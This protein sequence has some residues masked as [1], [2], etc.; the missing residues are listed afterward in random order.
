MT[1]EEINKNQPYL[2]NV[3]LG[4]NIQNDYFNTIGTSEAL[5]D[6]LST[7][8]AN[9]PNYSCGR[10]D[11]LLALLDAAASDISIQ[12]ST[13][14][15]TYKV[16]QTSYEIVSEALSDKSQFPFFHPM[17]PKEGIQYP[18]IVQLLLHFR[19]TLIGLFASDTE[20]GENFMR[21]F[22]RMLVR[23]GI[24]VVISQRFSTTRFTAPLRNAI[25]KWRQVNVF[26]HS[27]EHVPLL[28]RIIPFHL[29]FRQ[30]SG[31]IEGKV[32]ILTIFEKHY[33]RRNIYFK[34]IHSVWSFR[35]QEK[36]VTKDNAVYKFHFI[37]PQYR[38]RSLHCSFSK[39]A[40]SVKGRRRCTQ[41]APMEDKISSMKIV[42]KVKVFSIVR[43]L[44]HVLNAAYASSS[45][46]RRKKDK[47]KLRTSRLQPWQ[48]LDPNIP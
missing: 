44:T 23:N 20:N 46:R 3:T 31:P 16:A 39:H 6:M 11:N 42:T 35:L 8:D 33:M 1:I 26:L 30:L 40:F 7:G 13:L 37:E 34:Y 47:E 9:V 25:S 32:W 4:Y 45:R 38:D 17:F 2:Q 10:K 29:T 22:T 14:V 18:G 43:T 36:K 24:C 27:I 21:T 19:W 41:K 28:E 15:G 12:M 48:V 5:L